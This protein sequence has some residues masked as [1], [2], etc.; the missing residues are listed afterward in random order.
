MKRDK[1]ILR[2]KFLQHWKTD[3]LLLFGFMQ[4]NLINIMVIQ[5]LTMDIMFAFIQ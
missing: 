4:I 2:I 5:S 3:I 1:W